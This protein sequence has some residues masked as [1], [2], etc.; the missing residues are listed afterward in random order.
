MSATARPRA[1]SD[2]NRAG[3]G[4]NAE[5]YF[6]SSKRGEIAEWK[7]ALNSADKLIQK[8]AVKKVVG[9]MTVGRDVS[10]LFPD[11]VKNVQTS[12]I[13]LK[14][15]V[16]LYIMNYAKTKPELSVM[17]VNTFHQ[18]AQ[19]ANPLIRALAIRTM[20]CI[21]VENI[22]EY[23]ADPLRRALRDPDPYVRKTAAIAVSK[24]YDVAPDIAKEQGF[25]D[26]LV[27]LLADGN[28][29]VVANAVASLAEIGSLDLSR[30]IVQ[31][32]LTALNECSEWGQVF[33]LDALAN[34]VPIDARDALEVAERV[35]PRLNHANS[36]VVLGSV[37][38]ILGMLDNVDEDDD[39]VKMYC[40]KITRSL[41]T[42]LNGEPEIQYVALRNI[43][44][45]IQKRPQI[46]ANE[47]RTFFVKYNDPIFVKMEKLEIMIKLANERN[48]EQVLQEF[49]EYA[50]EVD[51]EF[52]RRAVRAIG[53]CAINLERAAP[54]CVEALVELIKTKVNYVVQE[55][56]VV[57]K[58]IFRK[59]PEKYESIIGTLCENLDTLDEPEAKASMIW[60]IGEYSPRIENAGELLENF[61]D[62]FTDEP[63][64]VQLAF[65]TAVVKLFLHKPE[66]SATFLQQVLTLTTEQTDN[67]D[68]RDRGFFY[69]RLLTTDEEAA[70]QIVLAPKPT[71]SDTVS[72]LD[73][74]L[75][76]KLVKHLGTLASVFHRPP[77]QFVP[78]FHG[79]VE[80]SAEELDEYDETYTESSG[81]AAAASA[82]AVAN[83]GAAMQNMDDLLGL[84]SLSV[85]SPSQPAAGAVRGSV[86]PAAVSK[87]LW[88]PADRGKGLEVYGTF[89]SGGSIAFTFKNT[90]S[91]PIGEF[92]IQFNKNIYGIVPG[93]PL[94]IAPVQPG[95]SVDAVLSLGLAQ[96]L[97]PY[98]PMLQIALKCTV[99]VV[100]FQAP[101]G[102]D[103]LL[104]PGD[105]IDKNIFLATWKSIDD[106]MEKSVA[107]ASSKNPAQ[108]KAAMQAKGFTY[109]TERPVDANV[110]MYFAASVKSTG[111]SVLVETKVP[112][113]QDLFGADQVTVAVRCG[114]GNL[115]EPTLVFLK[116]LLI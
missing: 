6:T 48:I 116:N 9:A 103:N 87:E 64:N 115:A 113:Q 52:V 96:N 67:P 42:L 15:L 108:V 11:L 45:I 80:E 20:G 71:I 95:A 2:A 73:R 70:R 34:Y 56:I 12:N 104:V 91:S 62:S 47:V 43:D 53:R 35:A 88:L 54:R 33:I 63:S 92:A 46:L 97:G 89:I 83:G 93:S 110:A 17:A 68:L 79:R 24:L 30:K 1:G 4:S 26:T 90:S 82:P 7:D 107:F 55:G 19:D 36:A 61:I 14:K 50:T 58:D 31:K 5:G 3:N 23:M 22:T 105:G 38:V 75:L 78:D 114:N 25:V 16:Y 66:E 102:V 10:P 29:S 13:E 112:M 27:E 98:N 39:N 72:R 76:N 69:W 100:Y 77:E 51:V 109:V 28:P 44:L 111:D 81:S 84:G 49:K 32:L 94:Q 85:G 18:D 41:V 21:R 86:S 106:S 59:Y 40:Q 37:K 8:D 99:G 74:T 57:I 101:F 65:L 60:I